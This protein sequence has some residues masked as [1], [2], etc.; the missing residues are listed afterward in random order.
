[1]KQN[2]TMLPPKTLEELL[3]ELAYKRD[4]RTASRGGDAFVS[5]PAEELDEATRELDKQL[6]LRGGPS[7]EGAIL[8][9]FDEDGSVNDDVLM[10]H[11][12]EIPT[13]PKALNSTWE[14]CLR[15]VQFSYT[16]YVNVDDTNKDDG[17]DDSYTAAHKIRDLNHALKG[18]VIVDADPTYQKWGLPYDVFVA[19]MYR[20]GF[21]T[22]A[23]GCAGGMLTI[24]IDNVE[25]DPPSQYE[26]VC[27][28]KHTRQRIRIKYHP[29][30]MRKGS[31]PEHFRNICLDGYER[32]KVVVEALTA[33]YPV[34]P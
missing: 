9:F 14:E 16:F 24:Q 8:D 25:V 10:T 13:L 6:G 4:K 23:E 32:L 18:C 28:G 20:K 1:M 11:A 12:A 30:K 27:C 19:K 5:T 26:C 21:S 29:P 22:A 34:Y 15:N 17:D 2:L 31:I 3:D 7:G 33:M